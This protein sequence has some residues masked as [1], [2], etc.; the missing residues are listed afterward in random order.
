VAEP[1]AV[2]LMAYGG[3]DCLADVEPYLID[4]RSGRAISP[5]SP[6]EV[7]GRYERIG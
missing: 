5:E 3:P 4:V 7:R 6:A 1:F 2:L